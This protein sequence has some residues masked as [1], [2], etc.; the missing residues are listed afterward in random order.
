MLF[1]D[2]LFFSNI[3]YKQLND[4]R[5]NDRYEENYIKISSIVDDNKIGIIDFR[6]ILKKSNA[7]KLLGNKFLSLEKEI[8][9]KIK[10]KQK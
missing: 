6:F 7:M 5:F 8:N 4:C 3:I 10:K 2:I 1:T 9:E